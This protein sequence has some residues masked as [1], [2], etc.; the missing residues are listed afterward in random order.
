MRT[1]RASVFRFVCFATAGLGLMLLSPPRS[2]GGAAPR[3]I[4]SLTVQERMRLPDNTGIKLKSGRIATL[5]K[6]RAEHRARMENFS[7]AAVLGR[8]VVG[9]LTNAPPVA[10]R[11][12]AGTLTKAPPEVSGGGAHRPNTKDPPTKSALSTS[13]APSTAMSIFPVAMPDMT[14][15]LY[16]PIPQDYLNFCQAANASTCVYLPA[17]TTFDAYQ[18]PSW[19]ATFAVTEDPLIVDPGACLSDGGRWVSDY[20]VC[21][22]YYPVSELLNYKSWPGVSSQ[23]ADC[24]GQGFTYT[25]DPRGAIQIDG[26]VQDSITFVT[27]SSARTCVIQVWTN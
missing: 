26:H 22:F 7:R 14:K 8:A 18:F 24:S 19:H 15:V 23:K 21:D 2:V 27:G 25:V 11:A 20:L 10:G 5:G 12:V 1:R 9:K 16:G 6:L 13:A 3:S 17:N 4:A